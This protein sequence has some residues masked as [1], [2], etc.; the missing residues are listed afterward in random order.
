M[1]AYAHMLGERGEARE[2]LRRLL[3]V[4][5][6]G[7]TWG[8]NNPAMLSWRSTAALL[9]HRLGEDAEA[10]RLALEE[11]EL[12]R[13]FGA[14]RAIGVAL[15]AAGLVTGGHSGIELLREAV[16]ELESSAAQLER[17][18]DRPQWRPG[19]DAR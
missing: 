16:T 15:R 19:A 1:R 11:V 4:A 5:D 3:E 9:H 8:A 12:A 2:G 10:R 13:R 6:R 14:P 18:R 17:A 7:A